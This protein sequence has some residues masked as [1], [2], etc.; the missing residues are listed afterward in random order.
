MCLL[1]IICV[2]VER[3][4][5]DGA[6]VKVRGQFVGFH[7]LLLPFPES[8]LRWL[9]LTASLFSTEPFYQPL[10]LMFDMKVMVQGRA[11]KPSM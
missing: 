11:V 4:A 5:H 10:V 1:K 8:K 3:H 9:A 7:P 6:R 2:C